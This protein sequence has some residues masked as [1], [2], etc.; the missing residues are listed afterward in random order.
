LVPSFSFKFSPTLFGGWTKSK[1]RII[2]LVFMP[3]SMI[4]WIIPLSFMGLRC[5][6]VSAAKLPYCGGFKEG[7]KEETEIRSKKFF[8]RDIVSFI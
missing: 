2:V 7:I 4:S 1:L 3:V 5:M 8:K 6:G